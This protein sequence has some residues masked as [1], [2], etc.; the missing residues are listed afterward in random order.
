MKFCY[1]NILNYA[2]WL[3]ISEVFLRNYINKS[4]NFKDLTFSSRGQLLIS[5]N[6]NI[7]GKIS[8]S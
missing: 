4:I 5:A 2:Y 6:I 7:F 1:E 3:K 8:A